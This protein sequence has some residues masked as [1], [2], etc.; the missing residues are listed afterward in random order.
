MKTQ[1]FIYIL[2]IV[3][4]FISMMNWGVFFSRIFSGSSSSHVIFVGGLLLMF[5]LMALPE[6]Y[7]RLWWLALLV[8]YGS[9]PW[10]LSGVFLLVKKIFNTQKPM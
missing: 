3:G 9:V 2:L 7:C 1:I 10:L 8:D 5:G 4:L 6:P